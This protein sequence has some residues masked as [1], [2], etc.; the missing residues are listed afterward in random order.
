MNCIK[1]AKWKQSIL[2]RSYR[3]SKA[4][5]PNL[6]PLPTYLGSRSC[7]CCP[8]RAHEW[9]SCLKGGW[10]LNSSMMPFPSNGMC[11]FA[12]LVLRGLE[13]G[14]TVG[15]GF[16]L[17]G[18]CCIHGWE[19]RWTFSRIFHFTTLS[20]LPPTRIMV[21]PTC[22]STVQGVRPPLWLSSEQSSRSRV[23]EF[24]LQTPREW[25][26]CQNSNAN[27]LKVSCQKMQRKTI[28]VSERGE[29]RKC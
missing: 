16:S 15:W 27:T 4:I 21:N 7:F 10:N 24:D 13:W 20:T 12:H 6:N 3:N 28:H 22:R 25:E 9:F 17:A 8:T 18:N 2:K 14:R 23:S 29:R 19:M 1:I 26:T 5:I 11:V